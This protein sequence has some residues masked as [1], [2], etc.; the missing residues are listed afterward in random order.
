MNGRLVKSPPIQRPHPL[1]GVRSQSIKRIGRG[2]KAS[3]CE[4]FEAETLQ[5]QSQSAIGW[6]V[7]GSKGPLKK[8]RVEVS[9]RVVVA[10]WD[11]ANFSTIF[12]TGIREK[13]GDRGLERTPHQVRRQRRSQYE[14]AFVSSDWYPGRREVIRS[15]SSISAIC[16]RRKLCS[17]ECL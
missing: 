12:P 16:H 3:L 5:L 14:P 15:I 6:S 13:P 2:H 10:G 4:S 9:G 1:E 8:R 11:T 7:D 17:S